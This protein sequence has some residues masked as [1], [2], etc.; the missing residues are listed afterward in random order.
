MNWYEDYEEDIRWVFTEAEKII[1]EFPEPFDTNGQ[2]FLSKFNIFVKGSSKS[3]ICFLL[4]FWLEDFAHLNREES[5]QFSL[6]NVFIMLF[7]HLQDDVM[8]N[9]S[10]PIKSHLALAN[11]IQLKYMSIFHHYFEASSK[12]WHYLRTYL[13]EW[14]SAVSREGRITGGLLDTSTMAHKAAPLKSALAGS[15]LLSNQEHQLAELEDAVNRTLVTLQMLDDWQDWEEDLALENHNSLLAFIRREL[16]IPLEA[17]LTTSIIEQSIYSGGILKRFA[18]QH[19]LFESNFEL[20]I[21]PH[22]Y[23][24]HQ[25]LLEDLQAAAA[26]IDSRRL[27]LEKGGLHYWISKNVTNT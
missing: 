24:F 5:R 10:S 1:Q 22:L 18:E 19:S 6:A 27:M 9:P 26:R 13:E 8:D 15:L 21:V 23:A 20:E 7:F 2:V 25:D 14:A 16:D 4:P 12:F 3:Y 11:L 17:P